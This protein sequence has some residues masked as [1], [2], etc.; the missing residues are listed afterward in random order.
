MKFSETHEWITVEN[1]T[2]IIG[3]TDYAQR[4]L[5]EIVYVE[6]PEVGASVK[7]GEEAAV[8]ES[9]K[10]ATDVYSPVSGIIREVNVTLNDYPET[11]NASPEDKGWIFKVELSNPEELQ[12]LMDGKAYQASIE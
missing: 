8:L 1:Q 3:V 9:T 6:L 11:V 5:G 7:S 10:A 4:E 2:G 12:A